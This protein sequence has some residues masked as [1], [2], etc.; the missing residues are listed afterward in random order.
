VS[1]QGFKLMV[2]AHAADLGLPSATMGEAYMRVL[3]QVTEG[4]S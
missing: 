4:L 2:G 3:S 1:Q